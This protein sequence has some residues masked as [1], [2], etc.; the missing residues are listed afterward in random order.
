VLIESMTKYLIRFGS[1][2]AAVLTA[3]PVDAQPLPGKPARPEVKPAVATPAGE[4]AA[5][6]RRVIEAFDYQGVSLEPGLLKRQVEGVKEFYL[7]IPNDDLS[8]VFG[9]IIAGLS[10]LYAATGDAA[11]RDKVHYLVAQ[12]AECIEPDGFFFYSRRPKSPHYTYDKMVGG[13]V[14]AHLYGHDPQALQHLRRIT[15]WAAKNLSRNRPCPSVAN[16]NADPAA[17]PVPAAVP[18]TGPVLRFLPGS[19]VKIEQL[20]GEVD[21]EFNRPTLSR[22]FSRFGVLGTDLGY[23]FEHE[24]HAYF[25]FGDTVGHVSYAEDTIAMTD[26]RDP[27]KGVRLD[28][29][30]A[31]PGKYLVIKPPGVSMGPFETPIGGISLGGRM[32]V[33]VR[34]SHSNDWSKDRAVLT[35]FIPPGTFQPLR[36]MSAPPTARF[37]TMS[38]H[39]QP[40]PMPRL[41]PGGPYVIIWGTGKYRQSDAYLSIVPAAHFETGKGTRYF[42]GLDAAGTPTWSAKESE[43]KPVVRNGTLGDLSVTWCKDLGL[44]LMTY[45]RAKPTDCIAFSCSRTPWGPWSEPEAIFNPVRDRAYGKFIHNPRGNPPDKLAGPVIGKPKTEWESEF[46]GFYAPYVVERFTKLNGSELNLYYVLSTWNPYV[47]VLMKSRLQ[48]E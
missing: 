14:G 29:L 43:A 25:L 45:D 5:R 7:A 6:R 12:W 11:C 33:A 42:T 20:I 1:I 34:T 16:G 48:V 38:L 24:G 32:Y 18:A 28:F 41:P 40:G 30:T 19:T 23:S 21:K 46:G 10:R 3:V 22:T 47:V 27:E 8:H 9:Q 26:A 36:T 31:S 15:Q 44:W 39:L 17:K 37:I 13:L 35:R 2:V 4:A